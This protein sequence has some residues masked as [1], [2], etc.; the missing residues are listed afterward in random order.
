MA[1]MA[2]ANGAKRSK[3]DEDTRNH[4]AQ[5]QSQQNWNSMDNEDGGGRRKRE[6]SERVNHILL[7]T[8][9][10]PMYPIT[11]DVIHTISSPHGQVLRIVVFKKHGVQAMVEYPFHTHCSTDVES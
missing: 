10:N 3:L 8:I 2:E 9:L 6:E 5:Q 11:T 7:F 1:Y 4:S